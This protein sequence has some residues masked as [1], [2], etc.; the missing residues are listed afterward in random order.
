MA[1]FCH[2]QDHPGCV[3]VA[4]SGMPAL[5]APEGP[6]GEPEPLLGS[7]KTT[8]TRHRG[9]CGRHQ[10]HLPA[11][12]LAPFDQF[13]FGGANGGIGRFPRHTRARQES[14]PEVFHGDCLVVL[15]HGT[16]PLP[17]GVDV[18]PSGFLVQRGGL[19]PR[20]Q[21]TL[22][23]GLPA[24]AAPASHPPLCPC[25]LGSTPLPVPPVGQVIGGIS[26]GGGGA[27]APINTDRTISLGNGSDV[28]AH[29]ERGVPVPETIPIDPHARRC[30]RQL[31]RPDHR[32]TH[33]ARQP[34]AVVADTETAH[35]VFQRRQCL[36]PR[37]KRGLA[38]TL[39]PVG[40]VK[41][42]SVGAQRLLLGHLRAIVEPHN[43]RASRSEQLRQL[44]KRGPTPG[45]LL[46]NSLIPQKPAA[47]PLL[48]QRTFSL[49]AGAQP[50]GEA[51]R[52]DHQRLYTASH[53]I[54]SGWTRSGHIATT[55]TAAPT[56]SCDAPNTAYA[57]ST[58]RWRHDSNRSSR[59]APNG[60]RRSPSWKRCRPRGPTR[61]RRTR[62]TAST[63][64]LS[65]SKPA[66]HAYSAR[67]TR[68][69]A[70][71]YRPFGPTPTLSPP[72]AAQ[73]WRSSS[74][75]SRTNAT[76]KA[77]PYLPKA[78]AKAF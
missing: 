43:A 19:T 15:D 70:R 12:P 35:G 67:S 39:N 57:S 25:K 20:P 7:R 61:H 21:V 52:L 16:R 50:V 74:A 24:S 2:G 29:N 45:F 27:H 40:I 53:Y 11:R 78:K 63:S 73:P 54:A 30:R 26:S 41:R 34:Q 58:P 72:L 10:H 51:L 28:T 23:R 75:M 37:L 71:S 13:P 42:G 31:T 48:E 44:A 32:D 5:F 47:V 77:L 68:T 46:V 17:R 33:P 3:P 55:S 36:L 64:W 65:R 1:E 56:T 18:L 8:R 59:C 49:R 4:L 22:R 38:P 69:Y 14:R 9:V 60:T 66:R 62:S 6:F 76:L